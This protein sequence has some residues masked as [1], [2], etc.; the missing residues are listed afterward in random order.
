MRLHGLALVV[1]RLITLGVL[2]QH[3]PLASE[4]G[5]YD[6]SGTPVTLPWNTYNY[7]N[8][9]HVNAAHYELPPDIA[10]MG[11]GKLVH[12][13]VIMRHHKVSVSVCVCACSLA[14]SPTILSNVE[15]KAALSRYIH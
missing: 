7:C 5:V 15:E 13:S 6:S 14:S 8:A 2:A 3:S 9:P 10:S 4:S 11:G 12:V 1:F